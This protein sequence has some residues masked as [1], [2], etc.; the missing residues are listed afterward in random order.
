MAAVQMVPRSVNFICNDCGCGFDSPVVEY[1][2]RG[3]FWGTPCYEEMQ[4][5]PVCGSE[6]F[7]WTE[8]EE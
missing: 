2:D 3:E 7:D 1:E 6:D 8:Q 4:Y 5:C